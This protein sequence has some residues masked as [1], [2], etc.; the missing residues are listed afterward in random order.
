M[1]AGADILGYGGVAC[2]LSLAAKVV[3][4]L[5]PVWL[6]ISC[7][8]HLARAY[9]IA[10]GP[11]GLVGVRMDPPGLG[12]GCWSTA[13]DDP[14]D[15]PESELI[16]ISP[17]ERTGARVPLS[18]WIRLEAPGVYHLAL[19]GCL[20]SR[21]GEDPGGPVVSPEVTL[22]VL[23]LDKAWLAGTCDELAQKALSSDD[24]QAKETAK[25]LSRIDSPVAVPY[26][27][28]VLAADAY[29]SFFVVSGL[30]RIDT[31]E[32][33]KILIE[34]FEKASGF[35]RERIKECL[36]LMKTR[37]ED[38]ELRQKLDAI[39]AWQPKIVGR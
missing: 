34:A 5:E 36:S 23:P 29:A 16:E 25:A 1:S 31:P 22:G 30:A 32:T 33:M 18:R 15:S 35:T 2:S 10:L 24:Q 26:L 12:K 19:I 17:N 27:K 7:E 39:L 20:G 9:T 6:D 4:A 38:P 3:G 28:K 14:F 13:S 21:A 8:N 11:G 37:I